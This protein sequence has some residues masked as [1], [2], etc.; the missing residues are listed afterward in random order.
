[1]FEGKKIFI[2]VPYHF[3]LPER[4]KENLEYLGFQVF[5]MPKPINVKLSLKHTVKHGYRKFIKKDKTFKAAQKTRNLENYYLDFLESVNERFDYALIVRPDLLCSTI[6]KKVKAKSQLVV[7]YQ[8]DGLDRFPQVIKLIPEFDRFFVF[9][10]RDAEKH[11]GCL[12]ITNFYFDD[13]MTT[14]TNSHSVFFIGTYMKNR[15]AEIQN[16]AKIF[17]KQ[18]FSVNILLQITNKSNL[19][20]VKQEGIQYID[21]SL[22]FKENIEYIKQAEIVLDFKNDIHYGLSFRTFEALGFGKK[23]ITNNELVKSFDFYDERN[24]FVFKGND[25]DGLEVFLKIPYHPIA[26]SIIAKYSFTNW[27]RYIFDIEPNI[28]LLLKDN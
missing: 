25:F 5:V 10:I 12:P 13:L 16:L 11:P 24:I 17:T 22:S 19:E 23:L 8:W 21:Y 26:D 9:D 4:F 15:I 2:S 20:K 18:N 14:A 1:M 3:G 7:A 27:I 6:I 28:P